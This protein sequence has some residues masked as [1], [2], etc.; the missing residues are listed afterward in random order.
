MSNLNK[1]I[2]KAI[3]I[4]AIVIPI[5]YTYEI[6]LKINI[7]KDYIAIQNRQLDRADD[8]FK[9]HTKLK[10][11]QAIIKELEKDNNST[12]EA[13]EGE[14]NESLLIMEHEYLQ[15]LL[16]I[17]EE[18]DELK[19]IQDEIINYLFE[20]DMRGQIKLDQETVNILS[21]FTNI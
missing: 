4:L 8:E 20:K 7:Q 14:Y 12:L 16:R 15:E 3:I 21:K 11:H 6:I 18:K 10:Q 1:S 19:N 9:E 17:K 13:V 5:I 2:S